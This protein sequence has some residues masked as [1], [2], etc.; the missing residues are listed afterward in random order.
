VKDASEQEVWERHWSSTAGP[1]A[2]VGRIASI[3]RR[4]VLSRA[5]AHYTDRYFPRSGVFVECGCGTGQASGLIGRDGR[6]LLALDFSSRA[7]EQT[8]SVSSFTDRLQAD[9]RTLPFR[10]ASVSGIW[11]LGVMEHFDA[12][13]TGEILSEFRRVLQ[14]GACAILFWP[15]EFGS[16]RWLLAPVEWLMSRRR[17]REFRV[18]PD[19][20]NRLRSRR[21]AADILQ[22]AGL[23]TVAVDFTPRDAFIHLV[24]VARRPAG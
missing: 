6:R 15:P 2:L 20:V 18:F 4:R 13:A 8:R 9:I 21:H 1:D 12:A 17:G 19:E 3:V 23:E 14:P 16:S 10:D 11:N 22:A 7:L 24:V 5:V